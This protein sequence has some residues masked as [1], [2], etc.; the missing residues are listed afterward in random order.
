MKKHV[1][2]LAWFSVIALVLFGCMHFVTPPTA[3]LQVVATPSASLHSTDSVANAVTVPDN[4]NDVLPYISGK[5]H[6]SHLKLN[7]SN[8][9]VI[10]GEIGQDTQGVADQIIAKSL[11]GE[12]LYIV[13]NSPGG[14]V[15]DG[16][17]IVSAIQ[18]SQVPVYTVC[19]GLCASM[20]AI[21]EAYGTKRYMV[22]RSLLMYHEA[23]G[24]VQ[25]QFNQ[26]RS[27]F[28]AFDR[29]TDKMITEVALR[30][31]KSPEIFKLSLANEV[32]LDSEDALNSGFIDGL[33]MIE[34]DGSSVPKDPT[35]LKMHTI[36]AETPALKEMFKV[37]AH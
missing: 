18:S 19:L 35:T 14:S 23:A 1:S 30:A 2:Q 3:K 11:N 24:G 22:D 9:I 25:G 32:W 8:T 26:M 36:F 13:I 37:E 28:N 33:V 7:P 15:M 6:I 34:F 16:A 5:K 4:S 17:L 12:P 21:I 31:G 20:A 10:L 27:R 29:F